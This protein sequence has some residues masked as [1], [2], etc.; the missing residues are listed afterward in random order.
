MVCKSRDLREDD[1]AP[2]LRGGETGRGSFPRLGESGEFPL[3]YVF[4]GPL[5]EQGEGCIRK[6]FW[7]HE[8]MI[9]EN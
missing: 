8:S 3:V 4:M 2:P 5:G 7:F 6:P 1:L 9:W